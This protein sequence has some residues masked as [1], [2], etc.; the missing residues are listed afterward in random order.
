VDILLGGT[1]HC[2]PMTREITDIE[3]QIMEGVARI[4][5]QE[6]AAAWAPMGTE[7]E[8]E[9]RQP[10]AQMQRFLV[11][12]EKTLCLN[13]DVKLAEA[14]GALNLVFPLSI[15]NTLLRKLS[16][17]WSYGKAR[18]TTRSGRKLAEKMM[19]CPFPVVLG[20]T[21]IKL[22]VQ[23]LLELNPGG[24]C[25]LGVPVRMPASLIIAGRETFEAEPVRHGRH[26]AAQVRQQLVT[27]LEERKQ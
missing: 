21:S 7:I 9:Q 4:I 10:P 19:E 2:E 25:N 12:A 27:S 24:V 18:A 5:C 22:P 16:T 20:M 1:G 14:R 15:S 3:E 6:L 26:R 13:F 8:L 23:T 17:D 11:P